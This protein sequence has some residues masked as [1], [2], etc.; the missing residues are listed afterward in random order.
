MAVVAGTPP[1]VT[2]VDADPSARANGIRPGMVGPEAHARVHGLS[3]VP[4]SPACQDAAHAALLEMSL[5]VSPRVEDWGPGVVCL[6]LAGLSRLHR[7][8]R[9]LA[10][11]LAARAAEVELPASV[12]IASTRTAARLG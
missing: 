2:V 8:E 1:A 12:A 3:L 6:H 7:D 11:D 4:Q 10:E 5:G 9:D